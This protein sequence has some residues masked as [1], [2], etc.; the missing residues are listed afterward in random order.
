MTP[1][2]FMRAY[3]AAT[4]AHDLEA[5]LSLVADDAVYLFSNRSSHVGK[6][7]IRQALLANFETIKA[8][9]YSIR[10]LKWLVSFG[11]SCRV[12]L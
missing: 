8:E 7:A 4:C 12:H 6:E 11:G 1:D 5:T 10:R 9:T 3:E 2:E